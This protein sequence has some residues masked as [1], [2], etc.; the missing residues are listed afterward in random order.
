M[1]LDLQAWERWSA[2]RVAIKKPMKSISEEAAKLKLMRFGADQEAV[3]DQSIANGWQG[4][5]ALDEKKNGAPS[6]KRTKEESD[7]RAQHLEWLDRE[8]GKAWD[9]EAQGLIGK[10]LLCDALLARYDAEAD[11]GSTVLAA[12]RD[13]LK[14]RTAE[15]LREADPAAVLNNYITKRLVLRLFNRAGISRLEHRSRERAVA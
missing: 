4:L 12:K 7:A 1:D 8:S 10:L 5:F 11:Q 2:Y 13:W 15:L 3:V 9:R 14:T 6:K